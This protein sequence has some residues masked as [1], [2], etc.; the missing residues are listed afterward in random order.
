M[1]VPEFW[2]A[3]EVVPII[4]TAYILQPWGRYCDLGI[5]LK[6]KT[7]Q[8]AYAQWFAVFVVAI[9]YFALIPKFGI[10]GAAWATVI[11]F[12]AQFYWISKKGK[13]Y[14]NMHLPWMKVFLIALLAI[15]CFSLNFFLP[16]SLLLTRVVIF[17]LFFSLLLI[18]PVLLDE[19]KEE[20]KLN[21]KKFFMLSRF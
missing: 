4:N 11:G 20:V 9:A 5:M 13:E 1:S 19:Q 12:S 17:G 7:I 16:D 15:V 10:K 6:K 14:Y 8:I 18:L 3:Y 21:M 2:P